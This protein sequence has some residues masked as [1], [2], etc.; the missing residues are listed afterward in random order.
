MLDGASDH[1]GGDLRVDRL[2]R[3]DGFVQMIK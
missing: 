3:V 2:E 1:S